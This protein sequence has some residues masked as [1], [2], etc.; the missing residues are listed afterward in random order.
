MSG[1]NYVKYRELPTR[2]KANFDRQLR[3]AGFEPPVEGTETEYGISM[4]ADDGILELKLNNALTWAAQQSGDHCK[5]SHR[6]VRAAI[7]R[8]LQVKA[9]AET[10]RANIE[11][12]LSGRT[13]AE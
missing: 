3:E 13:V 1:Y 7:N 11:K 10:A 4:P 8:F 9:T 6:E 12:L 5:V 2:I